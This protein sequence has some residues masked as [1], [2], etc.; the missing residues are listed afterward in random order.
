MARKRAFVKNADD[1]EQVAD[2]ERRELDAFAQEREDW[3]AMLEHMPFRRIVWRFLRHAKIHASV[4]GSDDSW[5]NFN[6]GVQDAGHYVMQHMLKA[7][8]SAFVKMQQENPEED[9]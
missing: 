5:T 6:A 8:A 3:R 7:D 4:K 1:A 2:G 9:E